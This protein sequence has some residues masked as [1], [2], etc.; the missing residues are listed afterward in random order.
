[1]KP[2][3]ALSLAV[4]TLAV[5]VA[6][7]ATSHS[8]PP[9][10]PAA[11]ARAGGAVGLAVAPSLPPPSQR[12][13]L[14]LGYI[15]AIPDAIA[16]AGIADGYFQQDLGPGITLEAIPY[17]TPGAE[18][19]ALQHGQIDAA[20]INPVAAIS[21]WQA[22]RH[23]IRII[24]GAASAGSPAAQHTTT[25]LAATTRLLTHTTTTRELL[26]ADV[27]AEILLATKPATAVQ[28]LQQQLAQAGK[29][30]TIH[31]LRAGLTR[32]H[33]TSNPLAQTIATEASQAAATG[34]IHPAADLRSIYD[35]TPLNAILKNVGQVPVSAQ[36]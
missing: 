28:A 1:V 27:Q 36:G 9:Q 8:R 7:C 26:E 33:L 24:A 5:A 13:T 25:V 3:A 10:S 20:Y 32:I 15:P 19:A 14:R 35:L 22:T 30:T 21:A 6:G 4:L 17:A 2:R 31:Q 16:L 18:T 12:K 11:R 29:R 23:Q 34:T